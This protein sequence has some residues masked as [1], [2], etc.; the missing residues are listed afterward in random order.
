[1]FSRRKYHIL[2]FVTICVIFLILRQ[3][4]SLE[5]NEGHEQPVDSNA[6]NTHASGDIQVHSS[7]K[8]FYGIF[9]YDTI[10]RKI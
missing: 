1:M 5:Q 3:G 10:F 9:D 2:A 6:F 8:L 4:I 7:A